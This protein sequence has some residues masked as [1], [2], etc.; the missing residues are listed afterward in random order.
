MGPDSGTSTEWQQA[1]RIQPENAFAHHDQEWR[2]DPPVAGRVFEQITT[3]IGFGAALPEPQATL[4]LLDLLGFAGIPATTVP[5]TSLALRLAER[6]MRRREATVMVMEAPQ[7]DLIEMVLISEL[8]E[9]EADRLKRTIDEL[10]RA[11]A[12]HAVPVALARANG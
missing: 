12:T 7:K 10:F 2:A 9:F 1:G 3:D 11:R 6:S 4:D 8:A 5:A